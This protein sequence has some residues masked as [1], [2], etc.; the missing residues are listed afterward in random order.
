MLAV[1]TTDL[2]KKYGRYY[3]IDNVSLA[4]EAGETLGIVGPA[5]AGKTTLLRLLM[6]FIFPSAGSG[7]ILGNN[8][9]TD[10]VIIKETTGYVPEDVTCYPQMKAG[11]YIKMAMRLHGIKNNQALYNLLDAFAIS[12]GETFDIMDRSDIKAT[13]IA[14]ALA[15]EPKVL[16][17]DEPTL[18]LTGEMRNTLFQLLAEEKAKGTTMIITA[19]AEEDLGGL[20]D[21]IATMEDGSIV[22]IKDAQGAVQSD[23]PNPTEDFSDEFAEYDNDPMADT[24]LIE[25][26]PAAPKGEDNGSDEGSLKTPGVAGA[27]LGVGAAAVP[28]VTVPLQIPD[29][30]EPVYTE[31]SIEEFLAQ[32]DEEGAI[33]SEVEP[34]TEMT[35]EPEAVTG[36]ETEKPEEAEAIT[37]ESQ[38]QNNSEESPKQD[39]TISAAATEKKSEVISEPE[40]EPEEEDTVNPKIIKA[41]VKG[42]KKESFEELGL[43]VVS[44][45]KGKIKLAYSGD[46]KELA[47]KLKA[48]GISDFQ[49]GNKNIAKAL[50]IPLPEATKNTEASKAPTAEITPT[51]TTAQ[52]E[53][54]SSLTNNEA[55]TEDQGGEEK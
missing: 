6:N 32:D 50:D 1:K 3:G 16:L 43:A 44:Q 41:K 26:L 33:P 45:E 8:I 46:L 53:D 21:R 19:E 49:T 47:A 54:N 13:G 35:G 52:E 36:A 14:A 18:D 12:K 38:E 2:T 55:A 23:E 9:V 22:Y 40:E 48:M 11:K 24:I 25:D 20:C 15:I 10:S 4:V 39:N 7:N 37:T 28:P 34:E 29:T 51:E 42:V 27:A 17:L 31:A 5:G 30:G